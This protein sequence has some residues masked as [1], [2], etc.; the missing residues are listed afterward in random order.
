MKINEKKI[1]QL[2][3][4]AKLKFSKKEAEDMF[5]DFR[6][7]LDFIQKLDQLNTENVKPLTHVHEQ[8][9]IYR[10]D[11]VIQQEFK[12]SILEQSFNHNTDYI[13]VPKII[14]KN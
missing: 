2:A 9:N 10:N 1:Q 11:D 7:I 5:T 12:T 14:K 13:K 8:S 6:K 4:L 3:N